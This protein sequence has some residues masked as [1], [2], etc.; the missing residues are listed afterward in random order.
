MIKDDLSG[1]LALVAQAKNWC[2][3]KYFLL[4]GIV[5]LRTWCVS[6]MIIKS[7]TH[8]SLLTLLHYC[9]NTVMY[10]FGSYVPGPGLGSK[11]L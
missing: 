9:R 7:L 8:W 3:I 6:V 11:V 5:I 2:F 4:F 1:W 10:D